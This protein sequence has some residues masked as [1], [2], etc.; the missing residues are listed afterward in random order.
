MKKKEIIF[1]LLVAVALALLISPFASQQPDGL[2]R[3]AGNKGFLEKTGPKPVVTS[4]IADYLWPGI[5]NAKLATSIAGLA[6][7]LVVFGFGYCIARLMQRF[8]S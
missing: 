8:R 7:T 1:A 5:K 3:V 4:P 6:G 2:E